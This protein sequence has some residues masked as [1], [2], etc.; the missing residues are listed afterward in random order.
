MSERDEAKPQD[1]ERRRLWREKNRERLREQARGWRAN[2]RERQR[3]QQRRWR[4]RNRDKERERRRRH[5][6]KN[7]EQVRARS[8]ERARA[9]YQAWKAAGLCEGC[10]RQRAD[11]RLCERCRA[12]QNRRALE[13]VR[14]LRQRAYEAYGGPKCACCGETEPLFLC[15]DHIDG[16]GN[17]HRRAI[18]AAGEAGG[19]F[20]Q[21]LKNKGYPPGFQ[22]LCQ[23]CNVGKWR[24]GGVCPHQRC[25][26]KSSSNVPS[27]KPQEYS[28]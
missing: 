12:S 10:G 23:N 11:E 16:G 22:V 24:N 7:L 17:A 18:T 14:R 20:Y 1:L 3:E 19:G 25:E 6:E 8:R 5:R 4:E 13:H 15:I 27:K 2:N 21:W 26:Q 28:K 9:K